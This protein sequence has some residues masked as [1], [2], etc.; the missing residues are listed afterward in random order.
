MAKPFPLEQQ[1]PETL[2][3]QAGGYLDPATGAPIP[4]I[5]P[6]TTFAR[7][8]DHGPPPLTDYI[9]THSPSWTSTEELLARL[10]GGAEALLVSSGMAAV[11][12]AV[13]GLRPG[14]HIVLQEA[15]YYGVRGWIR[16]FCEEWGLG[17]TLVDATDLAELEAAM[18]PGETKLVWIE[19]PSNPLWRV[20]DISA[21]A[22]LAHAAG[23]RLAVDNTVATPV[24]TRPLALGAD[25]VMHSA[26]K[27]LNGH[28][29]VLAGALVTARHDEHWTRI[30]E[31]RDQTGAVLGPFEAWLL[32][33]GMRT[34]PLRVRRQCETA[35]L[36]AQRL[37]GHPGLEA[38]L[39]PGLSDHPGHAIADRQMTGGFGGMLSLLVKGGAEEAIEVVKACRLVLPATSLG[40]VESLIE[41]R[42]TVEGPDSP[43]PKNLLRLSIGLE[44]SEDLAADLEQALQTAVL[45]RHSGP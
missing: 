44:H 42:A 11:H 12:A 43:V 3:A 2:A 19:T 22:G 9:R 6:A 28:G 36:L 16:R 5:Q 18:R 32:L 34:L 8:A 39:Y 21:V 20:V 40:G 1:H 26:T 23:A 27:Y 17:L 10:E 30:R 29:D 4:P 37:N 35:G 7:G 33:R 14:D 25:L 31:H 13:M 45:D 41:H 24:L 38:V 15:L